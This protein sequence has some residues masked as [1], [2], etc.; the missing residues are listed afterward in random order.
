MQKH[1]CTQG[2]YKVSEKGVLFEDVVSCIEIELQIVS[3]YL[4]HENVHHSNAVSF[5]ET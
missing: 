1:A 3:H 2:C 5:V 4:V